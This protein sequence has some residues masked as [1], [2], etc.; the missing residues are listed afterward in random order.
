MLNT[1]PTPYPNPNPE[2]PHQIGD[3]K[4]AFDWKQET[5]WNA[6]WREK[7]KDENFNKEIPGQ[8]KSTKLENNHEIY[9]WT[10]FAHFN[11]ENS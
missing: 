5:D 1:T 6:G 9:T 8:I 2:F 4:L 11:E 10:K 3:K 7:T